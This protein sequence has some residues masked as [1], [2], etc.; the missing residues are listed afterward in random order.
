VQRAAG[1]DPV[2]LNELCRRYRG[3]LLAEALQLT[4]DPQRAEDLVQ[5]F[6]ERFV[7]KRVVAAA[8]ETRGSFR[9]FLRTS[10][11]NY[12]YNVRHTEKAKKNGGGMIFVDVDDAALADPL[13]SDRRFRRHWARALLDRA[14]ARLRDEEIGAGRGACFE[15]LRNRIAGDD[16]AAPLRTIAAALGTSEG[17]LK[18]KLHRLR[19]RHVAVLRA[20]VA[21]TVERIEDVDGEL[22]E[23]LEAWSEGT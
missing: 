23:L 4:H 21:D 12:A 20:E 8:D 9:A 13:T 19:F 2:E 15:A 3:P 7:A 18:V 10:L 16:D 14:L 6:L 1:G 5:G 17:T 11:R 22:Y